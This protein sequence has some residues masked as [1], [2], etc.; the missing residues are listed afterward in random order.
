[1]KLFGAMSAVIVGSAERHIAHNLRI[2]REEA[3]NLGV[4]EFGEKLL[5]W[6]PPLSSPLLPLHHECRV[7][8]RAVC[9]ELARGMCVCAKCVRQE[10]KNSV[11]V[12]RVR[13]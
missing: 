8:V 9:D 6:P 5:H 2:F 4:G 1:M 3:E 13:L 10:K 11:V 12:L 7:M